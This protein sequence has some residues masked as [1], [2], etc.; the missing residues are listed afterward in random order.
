VI[1]IWQFAKHNTFNGISSVTIAQT[2]F[3]HLKKM[4]AALQRLMLAQL[5]G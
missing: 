5:T 1:G 2:I 3:K 4:G